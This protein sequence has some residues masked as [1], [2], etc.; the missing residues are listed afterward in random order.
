[1][2]GTCETM[3]P[4]DE[5]KLYVLLLLFYSLFWYIKRNSQL[6]GEPEKNC[7]ISSN[8]NHHEPVNILWTKAK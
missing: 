1:M 2:I 5:I 6:V 7:Y 4:D 3:C 8:E